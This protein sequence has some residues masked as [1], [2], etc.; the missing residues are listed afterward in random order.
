MFPGCRHCKRFYI[1]VCIQAVLPQLAVT[2]TVLNVSQEFSLL[3]RR[4]DT[5]WKHNFPSDL[6]LFFLI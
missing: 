5:F 2:Q 1:P 6:F 3:Y 4:K